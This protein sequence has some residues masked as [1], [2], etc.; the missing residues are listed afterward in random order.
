M[1]RIVLFELWLS[2][3]STGIWNEKKN[4]SEKIFC[5]L[6]NHKTHGLSN[7]FRIFVVG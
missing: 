4:W 7:F 2:E 3:F 1:T 5:F 6:K